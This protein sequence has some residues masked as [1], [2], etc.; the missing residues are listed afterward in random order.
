MGDSV[1]GWSSERKIVSEEH[2][3]MGGEGQ[4]ARAVILF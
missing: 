4:E 3:Q 2:V 1:I